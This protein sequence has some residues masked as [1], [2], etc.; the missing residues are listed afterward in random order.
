MQIV[1]E[2]FKNALEGITILIPCQDE[3]VQE[4]IRSTA[5]YQRKRMPLTL[6]DK[7][8]IARYSHEGKLFVR[9]YPREVE[10]LFTVGPDGEPIPLDREAISQVEM[11]RIME[12][13]RRDG[14][15]EEEIAEAIKEMENDRD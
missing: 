5:F 2:A 7:I 13:M 4:S 15:S 3:R 11:Q 9:I 6:S 12:L 14:K 10:E 1:D 8:G